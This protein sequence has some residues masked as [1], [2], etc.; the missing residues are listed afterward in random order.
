[1]ECYNFLPQPGERLFHEFWYNV[2]PFLEGFFVEDNAYMIS[3]YGRLYDRK[4]CKNVLQ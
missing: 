4:T 2:N 3:S 1:M